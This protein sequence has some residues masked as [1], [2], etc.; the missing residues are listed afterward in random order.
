M[1]P[2]RKE[3]GTECWKVVAHFKGRVCEILKEAYLTAHFVFRA[4]LGG[5]P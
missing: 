1:R 3:I 5:L 4:L 2:L